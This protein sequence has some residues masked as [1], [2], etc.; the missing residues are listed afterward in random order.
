MAL[1]GK[2]GEENESEET[3]AAYEEKAIAFW[4]AVTENIPQWRD[5][6]EEHL[7]PPEVRAEYINAHAVAFWSL[8][9][10]GKVLFATYPD[11]VSWKARLAHLGEVDWRKTNSEW[12]G[13]CMLGSDIITRRQT[14]EATTKYIQWKLGLIDE[15]PSPVLDVEAAAV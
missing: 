13:I 3:E 1:L 10:A 8:G 11:E 15:K 5:V 7:R 14:R 2:L 4:S 6:L 12:Q 9:T